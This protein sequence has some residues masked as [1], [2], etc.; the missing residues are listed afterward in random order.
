LQAR[1]KGLTLKS[2]SKNRN[3]MTRCLIK[4]DFFSQYKFDC[5]HDDYVIEFCMPFDQLKHIVDGMGGASNLKVKY[6]VGDNKFEVTCFDES[7]SDGE[8]FLA[9]TK[10][11]FDVYE[12]NETFELEY[13]FQKP[14]LAA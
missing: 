12:T 8:K 13:E 2:A 1:S 7:S 5:E 9:E 3:M 10:I 4:T 14:G 6:P 11:E